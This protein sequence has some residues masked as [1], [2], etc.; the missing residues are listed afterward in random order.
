MALPLGREGRLGS[1]PRFDG[2]GPGV[3]LGGESVYNNRMA[4]GRPDVRAPEGGQAA[5]VQPQR[6]TKEPRLYRVLLHN[7]DYT[8]MEFVVM[9]L[10]QIFRH[11]EAT[12]LQI[13]LHVHRTGLGVA[14]VYPFEIAETRVA[15]VAELAR[16]HEYPLRC[17]MEMA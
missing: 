5:V 9:V 6:R 10:M 4:R 14:G 3:A 12:A 15:Q 16:T 7:D 13:M 8:T 1:R 17:T 11:P 2:L